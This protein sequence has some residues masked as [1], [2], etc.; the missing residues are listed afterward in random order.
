MPVSNHALAVLDRIEA[1]EMRSLEWGFT[2]GSLSEDE[3]FELG[4]QVCAA[5]GVS[6]TDGQDLVE[7]LI[8]AKLIFEMASVGGDVRIRS[9]FAEMMR[10]L[11]ANRQ[12][13]PNKPWQGA[14]SLVADFRVDCRPRRFPKRQR[15]P[16]DIL[17]EHASVLGGS[18][19]RLD[20]WRALTS[21]DGMKLAGFQERAALRLS[22]ATDDG[23]TIVTAGTGSGKTIA[24]YLPGMIRIGEA[25]GADHWVKAIAIY[26]RIELLK[27]Q[28]AEA[29]RMARTIDQTLAAHGRRPLIIGALFGKT[30]TRATRQE[31]TEK[32]WVRRG[33][34]FV[35]PW[36]R[37]PRCEGELV[38]RGA[39]I[40]SGTE[41][42]ACV[43]PSC[44][45][46][47]G[48]DLIV[49][50][51]TR[52][53]RNP[54]DI[55][56]TT[57]EILNQR[58]SDHWMR[59]LFGV[60]LAAT[61]KPLLA[62]LDEVHTY[63][64]G[65][66]AQ[67]ALTLR[68]W[69]HLL[70]APISWVGLSATLGDAARFFSDLTGAALDDVV[71]I[72][73]TIEEFE[74]Q[75]AE[76]QILL[77][78]DPAS[79]ASL[80]STTI[81]TSMLLPRLLDPPGASNASGTFGRRAF[82]FTDDLDVTN[83]LYDDLR[84]AEAFTIFGRPDAARTPLANIRRAG[85]DA[86]VRDVEGQ[87]WRICE[88]IGHP[89]DRRLIVGRTTSQ[90]AGVNQ[91]ANIVVA[92]AALEVGFNDPL[93]GAV[94]QHKAPR[95]MASFLQRKGRAGRDRAMR[96]I[97]LT[98]LSDYGRDR[99][100]Y[101]AFEHLF[102]PSLEPQYLPIRNP[103]VM[104]IQAVFALFDWLAATTAGYEKAWQWNLLSRPL[105][106]ASPAERAV[107]DRTR[108]KLTQLV[109]GDA[110]IID[111]LRNY[112]MGALGIDHSAAETLLWEAPR[113][114][115]L[116]AVPTLVRRLF[117]GWQLAIPNAGAPLDRQV[118]HHPL[119][120]FV[121]RNL[122]SDL[123]LPEVRVI[124][125]PATVNHEERVEQ[126]PILQA[127]N[128]FVPGRVTRRF[129]HERGA[130]SHWIPVDPALPE[131][132]RRISDYALE[133]EFV[134]VFSGSLND[135][136]G[137]PPLL[138]F[139][140]WAV[141]LE[142]AARTEALPSS[143]A[144]L[145]WQS[146]IVAN[147]DALGVPVPTRSEWRH[148]VR[149][150]DFHLHRFRSSV[151]V[152]RFAGIAQA[153]I[154]T[155]QDDFPVTLAFTS[156]DDR[157]AAVGFELEVDG[158][159]LDL[160]LP[161]AE[162]LSGDRLPPDV[163]AANRLAYIRDQIRLDPEL[164][165]DLNQFQ[166]EWL[167]QFL[168]SALLADAAAHDRPLAETIADLLDDDRI[169][170]VFRAVMDEVFGAMPPTQP[171]SDD[172]QDSDADDVA[173]GGYPSGGPVGAGGATGGGRLQQALL[174]QIGR[175]IVRD[176]L[177]ALAAQ[178]VAVDPA[179]FSLWLR[180][181]ILETLGEAML[182]A[183][184][185]AAPKQA[186]VETLL[187][188]I[189][190][191]ATSDVASVWISETTL[192]GAGVLEAFADRFASEP[193]LF[194]SAL[195]AA[196]APSDLELVD[197]SLR[198]ILALSINDVAIGDQV[199]LLRATS[200]HSERAALW[201]ALSHSLAQRG[202]I[203]LSHALSVSLNNRLLRAGSGP[204]LDQLLLDLQTHWDATQGRFGIAIGLREYAYIASCDAT[205]SSAVRA[206]LAATLPAAAIAHVTVLSAITSLMWP[207]ANEV[208]Q[209][210]LQSY[211]PFRQTRSTD[212][213][214][215]RHLL[216][217]RAIAT[218]AFGDPD[219]ERQLATAFEA[220]GTARLVADAGEARL[221]RAA[222]VRLSA[223]PVSV[224]VLQFFPAIER[225]ER[226]DGRIF[227]TLTL[228]EQV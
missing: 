61:R 44:G 110:A 212:P 109:Q 127:L 39:D 25:I 38:W 153:N 201:R 83:R 100:F 89:L 123:S 185:A 49:L 209:R 216:L 121:P 48:D 115:L 14:P 220:Q 16:A 42:L 18:Q 165:D 182:Q 27:D 35:C 213:A 164:P 59:G 122:F 178:L 179:M 210:V 150:I 103:Y 11:A 215:V 40:A 214:V 12:L 113:S 9:R 118:D 56:F 54:P 204:Q 218:I 152:R 186:T 71:E 68:R 95:G 55:L 69:R 195:D 198:E 139:R 6:S 117:R 137:G 155:L 148:Y 128:Q 66:G 99:A 104:K 15:L 207:R 90:D 194:F 202:G 85:P 17:A 45:Q 223:A 154:R 51:R 57:T 147:G 31:L 73:P 188:D 91:S 192:G 80:L 156:D 134:G 171:D 82:L 26:P 67:A 180:R 3:A 191:D 138:V 81:Q 24:F 133:H 33:E 64:G 74:E 36:M 126:M 175:P 120:D 93:V 43:Q 143:N 184:I 189:R 62:L 176:R 144:R 77:R 219:W 157:P 125:P 21:R 65:T 196:L 227:A 145:L 79:R 119:P 87:R 181:L 159:R 168:L 34:D 13:F 23:G 206:F 136:V 162:M 19:L 190:D 129:A 30:P 97:T 72:T 221:F 58:L 225:V 106:H 211:N 226:A 76:Y 60:G 37:C 217:C 132:D 108:A 5:A 105:P 7:E 52:L 141:R 169:E 2:D 8:D 208:R 149:A 177:R 47:I 98:V 172:T 53:Q 111:D 116:E 161:H 173:D 203:D 151:S 20:L 84:D 166:R 140:P 146:D 22:A 205:L 50:T 28:F 228:R 88:D 187:V 86:A 29:F 200:S 107:L 174:Q 167:V 124:I 94:I 199:A 142:R 75:G 114:L 131:Q 102:D 130:L 70:A 158:F 197:S 46:T 163:L 112:L 4:D 63:E 92:T 170:G 101:Q 78:G 10:L 183:C 193:R 135:H 222:L 224:G 96:P 160:A 32:S 1:I 41:R